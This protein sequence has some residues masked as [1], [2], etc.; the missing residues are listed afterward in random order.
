MQYSMLR[1][2]QDELYVLWISR[3][4]RTDADC[5]IGGGQGFWSVQL[6]GVDNA[7]SN[8]K[9]SAA[10]TSSSSDS[11]STS[12]AKPT[13]SDPSSPSPSPKPNAAPAQDTTQSGSPSLI[14]P[15]S[16]VV[17]TAPGQSNAATAT[18][19]GSSAG[20][21]P[22]GAIA[23]G[24]IVGVA[25]VGAIAGGLFFFLRHRRRAREEELNQNA[26]NPFRNH[27]LPSSAASM[28]DSR[29]EPSVM[30]QRRQSDGSIADN[31]DYSRRIL[32]VRYHHSYAHFSQQR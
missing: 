30:M 21:P 32:Q 7:V 16:T 4:S 24:A 13:P 26:E 6:T 10:A 17:I 22:K 15:T 8:I 18:A 28:S 27:N 3:K 12:T 31:Q 29:L 5:L 1:I 23:A 11:S 14:G 20:G 25:V 2:R 9:P 19:S